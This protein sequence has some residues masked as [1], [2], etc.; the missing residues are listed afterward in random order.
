MQHETRRNMMQYVTVCI[1]S[2]SERSM[3]I[4]CINRLG[5]NDDDFDFGPWLA[6][7]SRTDSKALDLETKVFGVDLEPQVLFIWLI[8][9]F[10]YVHMQASISLFNCE[11]TLLPCFR[12]STAEYTCR[13]VGVVAAVPTRSSLKHV[14]P[15]LRQTRRKT[16]LN[17][18]TLLPD[19]SH[20]F[21]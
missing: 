2:M 7:S 20:L 4:H 17:A 13:Y 15:S 12:P 3:K 9:Y 14:D 18:T 5:Y 10:V 1:N 19:P 11:P 16:E 21:A 8:F 6:R